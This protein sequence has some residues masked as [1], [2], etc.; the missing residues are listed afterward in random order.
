MKKVYGVTEF[1]EMRGM[2]PQRLR[3]LL[4]Q[5]RVFPYQRLDNG[6]YLLFVNTVVVPPYERPNRNMRSR[7]DRVV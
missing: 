6:R 2:H 7:L 1:A 5:E 4:R 3:K